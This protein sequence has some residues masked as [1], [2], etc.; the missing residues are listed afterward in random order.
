MWN[1]I[2]FNEYCDAYGIGFL[3]QR[4]TCRKFI[5]NRASQSSDEDA[6]LRGVDFLG[7]SGF[8]DQLVRIFVVC[9]SQE[10]L[11]RRVSDP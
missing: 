7:I 9:I 11:P 6:R 3:R 5:L 4:F 1:H 10:L 8:R 2:N